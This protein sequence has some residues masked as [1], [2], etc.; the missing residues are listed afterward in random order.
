MVSSTPKIEGFDHKNPEVYGTPQLARDHPSRGPIPTP[1]SWFI[2]NPDPLH[3]KYI[4]SIS[5]CKAS[6]GVWKV[7]LQD[8]SKGS[9]K[10][11]RGKRLYQVVKP[12]QLTNKS[13]NN[14]IL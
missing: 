10:K 14:L 6:T 7:T 4:A 2:G 3:L 5:T 9:N 11:A 12:T 13:S 8:S 1:I